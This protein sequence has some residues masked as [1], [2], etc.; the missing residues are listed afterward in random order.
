[1]V[2]HDFNTSGIQEVETGIRRVQ[3]HPYIP[4]EVEVSHG[5]IYNLVSITTVKRIK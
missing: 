4:K 3:V 1:M 5:D 2:A